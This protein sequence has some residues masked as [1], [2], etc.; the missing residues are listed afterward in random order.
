MTKVHFFATQ[1]VGEKTQIWNLLELV[2]TWLEKRPNIKITNIH[3]NMT[4]YTDSVYIFISIW[5]EES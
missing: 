1:A 3:Q 5:Y 2:N 4:S